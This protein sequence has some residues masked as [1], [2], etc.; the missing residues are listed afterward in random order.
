MS[1]LVWIP[2]RNYE[3][4]LPEALASVTIQ[5]ASCRVNVQVSHDDCGGRS[6]VGTAG[7]RN[8]ALGCLQDYHYVI[9]LDADDCFSPGYIDALMAIAHGDSCVVTCSAWR[10]G[11]AGGEIIVHRP[12]TLG[13]ILTG[14]TIH[15]SALISTDLFLQSGGFDTSLP[16]YEDWEL[17][18]RLAAQGA[19]FR[20]CPDAYLRVRCHA[21]SRH[22]TKHM[23]LSEARSLMY[24]RYQK[25]VKD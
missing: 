21:D 16:A 13:T 19:E 7:N 4:Y 25:Y 15:C 22:A 2:C 14:N 8:R 1:C 20:Y 9:F 11:S 23:T 24:Q 5:P 17:W 3:C 10:F 6:P 18:C 12:I